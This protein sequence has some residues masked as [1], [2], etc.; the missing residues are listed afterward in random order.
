M[1]LNADCTERRSAILTDT[2]DSR[3]PILC[4]RGDMIAAVPKYN[5]S[6]FVELD[7]Q[8]MNENVCCQRKLHNGCNGP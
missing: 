4:C 8:L 3:G 1:R 2:A 5:S 6:E 7:R